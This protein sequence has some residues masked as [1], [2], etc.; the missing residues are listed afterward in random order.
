MKILNLIPV[1][2]Y[3]FLEELTTSMKPFLSEGN[4]LITEIVTYGPTSIESEYDEALAQP[5]ILEQCQKAEG[6]AGIFINCFGDPAVRAAREIL[7]I[8]VVGG[9]E[10]AILLSLGLADRVGVVIVLKNALPMLSANVAKAHL[11]NRIVS[12]RTIDIPVLELND[13]NKIIKAIYEE[14]KKAIEL[15]KVEAIIL[16][17]TGMAGLSDIIHDKLLGDGYDV[18][19]IDPTAA[20]IKLL[21]VYG[22][23]GL[24]PSKITYMPVRDK[25]RIEPK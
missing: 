13:K 20:A 2:E 8:P 11:S 3:P 1:A 25:Q 14:A 19:V 5:A 9:F 12:I 10:P 24:K 18:P 7:D 22:Q 17:C 15:D 21:E 6:C 16:G 23:L 4:E